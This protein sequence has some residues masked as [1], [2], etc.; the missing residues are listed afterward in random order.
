MFT[1]AMKHNAAKRKNTV[2]PGRSAD[3]SQRRY[4]EG[5]KEKNRVVRPLTL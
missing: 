1:V 2:I 4:I 3:E 5:K